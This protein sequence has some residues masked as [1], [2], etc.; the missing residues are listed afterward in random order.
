ASGSKAAETA[1]AAKPSAVSCILIKTAAQLN[2]IRNNLGA[3]Y[4]LANDIDLSSIANFVPIGTS[5]TPFTGNFFGNNHTVR[6][7]KI[8]ASTQYV[9]LFSALSGAIIRD[10]TLENVKVVTTASFGTVGGL[11]GLGF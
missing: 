3:S 11:F 10:L 8:N 6:N 7:L 4:C 1:D 2:A 9:G 5:G